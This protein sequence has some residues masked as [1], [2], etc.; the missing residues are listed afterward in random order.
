MI[1]E[2]STD[3]ILNTKAFSDFYATASNFCEFIET[4]QAESGAFLQQLTH[5]L[6]DLYRKALVL[7]WVRLDSNVEYEEKLNGDQLEETIAFIAKH[8]GSTRNYWHLFDPSDGSDK[9]PCCGDLVDDIGDIYTDLKYDL[10]IFNLDKPDCKENALWQ[11]KFGFDK[12][13]GDHCMNALAAI[14]FLSKRLNG[15]Y[16]TDD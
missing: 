11:F 8:L 7:S 12:H 2:F 3:Y 5:Y 15:I 9:E 10:L 13:W 16:S 4:D 1:E 6:L 14:H